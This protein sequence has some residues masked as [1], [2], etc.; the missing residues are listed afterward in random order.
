D[1]VLYLG[2]SGSL[3]GVVT[4]G[5]RARAAPP[6]RL[7]LRPRPALLCVLRA[8]PGSQGRQ[9][10]PRVAART[11]RGHPGHAR[12]GAR[13]ARDRAPRADVNALVWYVAYGSN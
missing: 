1:S 7:P 8:V 2:L 11:L 5:R 3:R 4:G 6:L 12:P 10:G 13:A 9:R